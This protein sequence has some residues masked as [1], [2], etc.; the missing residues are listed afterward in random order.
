MGRSNR[1]KKIASLLRRAKQRREEEAKKLE[2]PTTVM[3]Q[4][5]CSVEAL[6][7]HE[8]DRVAAKRMVREEVV[9]TPEE[10]ESET[11]AQSW[12]GAVWNYV[13]AK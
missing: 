6:E 3:G 11:P 12:F 1:R 9:V 13:F 7:R 2:D 4:S 5:L 8:Q 10:V